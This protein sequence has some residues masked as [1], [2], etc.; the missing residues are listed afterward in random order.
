MGAVNPVEGSL[1]RAGVIVGGDEAMRSFEDHRMN[2]VGISVSAD[3]EA[4]VVNPEQKTGGRTGR[5][6][7]IG[8]CAI[9]VAEETVSD[10]ALVVVITS[11]LIGTV[12]P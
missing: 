10:H 9:G 2:A 3:H 6:D 12:D 1:D 5:I 8:D 4:L 7:W 11:N